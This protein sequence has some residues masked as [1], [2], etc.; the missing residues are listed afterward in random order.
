MHLQMKNTP[1]NFEGDKR[2]KNRKFLAPNATARSSGWH[3]YAGK[4]QHMAVC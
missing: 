4:S 2:E 3:I 1:L